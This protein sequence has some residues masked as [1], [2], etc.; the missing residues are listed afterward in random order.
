MKRSTVSILMALAA[1]WHVPVG[2]AEPLVSSPLGRVNTSDMV[3]EVSALPRE[4]IV[5]MADSPG[6]AGR[7]ATDILMRRVLA[8]RAEADTL[9]E[10]PL[11]AGRLKLMRERLL[12]EAYLQ[13]REKTAVDPAAVEKLALSDYRAHPERF[14]RGEELHLR[15]LL[16]ARNACEADGGRSQAE[17]LR[18]RIVAGESFETLAKEHS[19]DKGSAGKGGDLG[20]VPRG[21]TVKPFEDAAFALAQPGALSEVVETQFGFHI[22][23]LEERRSAGTIPFEEVREQLAEQISGR[24]RASTRSKIVADLSEE[25]AA[26]VDGA[27]L[28]DTLSRLSK[29]Q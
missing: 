23:R 15:H 24:I 25:L 2:G 12:A 22:I 13:A 26:Q 9:S 28:S 27:G 20:F 10:D 3:A 19:A 29:E 11:I 21:R 16:V 1:G 18:A 17:A 6:L 8:Q 4:R 7:V 5:E 14:V